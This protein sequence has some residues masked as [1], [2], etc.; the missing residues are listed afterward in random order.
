MCRDALC[1]LM[2]DGVRPG[3]QS[4]CSE[5]G[6]NVEAVSQVERS[7]VDS[8]R[9]AAPTAR[10]QI[11]TWSARVRAGANA[12]RDIADPEILKELVRLPTVDRTD[13]EHIRE[14]FVVHWPD[15]GVVVV[16]DPWKL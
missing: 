13:H 16:A 6:L 7:V 9:P 12:I 5:N 2:V 1:K 15:H 11:D 8:E 10:R 3:R 4:A 14:R